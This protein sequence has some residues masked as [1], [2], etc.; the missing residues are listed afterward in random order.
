MKILNFARHRFERDSYRFFAEFDC[1]E[2]PPNGLPYLWIQVLKSPLQDSVRC[3]PETSVNSAACR[4]PRRAMD[5]GYAV[6][7]WWKSQLAVEIKGVQSKDGLGIGSNQEGVGC[8]DGKNGS[9]PLE[10]Q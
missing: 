10:I 3:D 8:G 2:T 1:G 4:D 7:K 5:E 9:T 6:E